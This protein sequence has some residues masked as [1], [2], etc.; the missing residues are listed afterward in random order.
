MLDNERRRRLTQAGQDGRNEHDPVHGTSNTPRN[1][2]VEE[3]RQDLGSVRDQFGC[4]TEVGE[5]DRDVDESEPGSDRGGVE[6]TD[7]KKKRRWFGQI[8]A[9]QRER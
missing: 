4:L 2:E 5:D 3:R 6:L 7:W 8:S 9:E 1:G